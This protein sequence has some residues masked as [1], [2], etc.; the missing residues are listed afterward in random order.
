MKNTKVLLIVGVIIAFFVV[1]A[2]IVT[3]QQNKQMMA[4]F[5]S[6]VEKPEQEAGFIGSL[7]D[8]IL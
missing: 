8:K 7:I 5:S 4:I 3:S 1:L 6:K 2:F